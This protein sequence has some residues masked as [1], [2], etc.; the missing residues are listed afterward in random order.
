MTRPDSLAVRCAC[1]FYRALLLTY[2]SN[3]RRHYSQEMTT[4]FRDRCRDIFYTRGSHSLLGFLIHIA[5]DWFKSTIRESLTSCAR[6]FSPL[7]LT[8]LLL[9]VINLFLVSARMFLYHP[10]LKMPGSARYVLEPVAL[11][12]I[13]AV[14]I[15]WAPTLRNP[16]RQTSVKMGTLFGL[17][18]GLL[19]VLHLGLESFGILDGRAG[20]I[21]TP[22]VIFG[23][24]LLWGTA[25]Y[26]AVRITNSL[27]SGARAGIWSA[28]VCILITVTFGFALMNA[29][30][31]RPDYVA[32]WPEFHRS[33]WPDAHAFSIANT[34]EAAF[35]HLVEGPIIGALFGAIAGLAG[36]SRNK[37]VP[38]ALET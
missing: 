3:F 37:S 34:M 1:R 28:I 15:S 20:A 10:L 22:A 31:P 6:H 35:E 14:A 24:F 26:R 32:T 19:F 21:A 16:A 17:S 13:Y 23:S 36:R 18:T 8:F 25:G 11:L 2:P 9:V 27:S 29:G 38:Q 4:A 33:G 12:M 30:I 5:A 7:R